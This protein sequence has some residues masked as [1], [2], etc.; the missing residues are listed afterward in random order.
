MSL[1]KIGSGYP[2]QRSF[3]NDDY[4][5]GRRRRRSNLRGHLIFSAQCKAITS[6]TTM[7]HVVMLR[8]RPFPLTIL[9]KVML[10]ILH[11][12]IERVNDY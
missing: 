1:R 3:K 10:L 6:C 12:Q 11:M 8:E 7:L 5:C 4:Y 9:F 2:L